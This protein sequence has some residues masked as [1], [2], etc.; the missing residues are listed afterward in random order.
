MRRMAGGRAAPSP[1]PPEVPELEGSLGIVG[2]TGQLKRT[3]VLTARTPRTPQVHSGELRRRHSHTHGAVAEGTGKAFVAV[4]QNALGPPHPSPSHVRTEPGGRLS[5][6]QA[7]MAGAGGGGVGGGLDIELEGSQSMPRD[8]RTLNQFSAVASAS[9]NCPVDPAGSAGAAPRGPAAGRPRR[10]SEYV[11]ESSSA[12]DDLPRQ[13]LERR[14]SLPGTVPSPASEVIRKSLNSTLRKFEESDPSCTSV[15]TAPRRNG[16]RHAEATMAPGDRQ[17]G[18]CEDSEELARH[19]MTMADC[20]EL[21]GQIAENADSSAARRRKVSRSSKTGPERQDVDAQT[22]AAAQARA[23]RLSP[24]HEQELG[25]E[26]DLLDLLP[27]P[28][29]TGGEGN[30]GEPWSEALSS[31]KPG[32]GQ[33]EDSI[34]TFDGGPHDAVV[35]R[36]AVSDAQVGER[37]AGSEWHQPP[38]RATPM[39]TPT[40]SS[41]RE[42]SAVTGGAARGG[43]NTV[44]TPTE[45]PQRSAVTGGAAAVS[46][47]CQGEGAEPCAAERAERP[48]ADSAEGSADS[49]E[50]EHATAEETSTRALRAPARRRSS[51]T[52]SRRPKTEKIEERGNE[53]TSSGAANTGAASSGRRRSS[54]R[55]SKG[56]AFATVPGRQE[57]EGIEADESRRLRKDG[58]KESDSEPESA[59]TDNDLSEFLQELFSQYSTSRDKKG[60]PLMSNAGLR[61][62]LQDFTFGPGSRPSQAAQAHLAA[63]ADVRYDEEIERQSN[64][65]TVFDLTKGDANRG[66]CFKSFDIVVNQVNMPCSSK[67]MTKRWFITYSYGMANP[68]PAEVAEAMYAGLH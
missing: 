19:P 17:E 35:P 37:F 58:R 52:S 27:M 9:Q 10:A 11:Q 29:V 3:A 47:L 21:E 54:R 38:A 49:A 36:E 16:A 12:S 23:Q 22:D 61:R 30:E 59:V 31:K 24:A 5:L 67:E 55:H 18:A 8:S 44:A 51:K 1:R 6:E 4:A 68:T 33:A 57:A 41:E 32:G 65:P 13:G 45:S 39:A 7:G 62:F 25:E 66:L 43:G 53:G 20:N 64:M 40:R 56:R 48:S 42:T 2:R 14:S 15:T 28:G 63:Q 26:G 46:G 34:D 60:R 50:Q